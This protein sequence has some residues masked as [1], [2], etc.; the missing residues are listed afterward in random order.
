MLENAIVTPLGPSILLIKFLL[1]FSPYVRKHPRSEFLAF[2]ILNASL[3]KSEIQLPDKDSPLTSELVPRRTIFIVASPACRQTGSLKIDAFG[4]HPCRDYCSY[5]KNSMKL[6]FLYSA[7]RQGFEPRYLGPKPSV[8]PLDDRAILFC[9]ENSLN[10]FPRYLPWT[11]MN[12]FAKCPTFRR[13][14][15]TSLKLRSARNTYSGQRK[16]Y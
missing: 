14:G 11:L 4:S 3:T 13:S 9:I 16:H 12:S 5:K 2:L 7:A 10:S 6:F 15:T 1:V 8:L